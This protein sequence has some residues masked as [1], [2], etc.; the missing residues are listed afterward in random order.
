MSKKLKIEATINAPL[1][2]VWQCW[3]GAEHITQWNFASDDWHCPS[4][5]NDLRVGG[6]CKS[7]MEAKD[8]SFGFDMEYTYTRVEPHSVLEY[9]L[10][11][12]REIVT[13]FAVSDGAT[14][15]VTEFAPETEHPLEMQQQGWQ[16]ILNN[17]KAYV[18]AA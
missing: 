3:N 10:D 1:E 8:G 17:F 7:R 15:V 12:G 9:Q 6:R 5:E 18:E 14:K 11:D 16:S 13:T 2:Q 4:A